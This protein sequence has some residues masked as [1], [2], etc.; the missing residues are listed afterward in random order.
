MKGLVFDTIRNLPVDYQEVHRIA[1]AVIT[2]FEL[3][4]FDAIKPMLNNI[5]KSP[6]RLHNRGGTSQS[7][8]VQDTQ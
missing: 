8:G 7:P 6:P 2:D 3:V 5:A 1:R 4:N